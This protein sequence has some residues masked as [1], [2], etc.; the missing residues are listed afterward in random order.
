MNNSKAVCK[1][2]WELGSACG[3]CERCES[4]RPSEVNI[5]PAPTYPKPPAPT[6]PAPPMPTIKPAPTIQDQ[7]AKRAD[8]YV[9][10]AGLPLYTDLF[11]QNVNLKIEMRALAAKLDA[12]EKALK[13]ANADADM[14]AHAWQRE[15]SEYNGLIRNKRH[16]I[17]AMV[18]TTQAF[19]AKLKAAE[20]ALANVQPLPSPPPVTRE[21]ITIAMSEAANGIPFRVVYSDLIEYSDRL[22]SKF[23]A[24]PGRPIPAGQD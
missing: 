11:K 6:R 2:A 7:Y 17:D 22:L 9:R 14:Y 13:N 23:I 20:T 19:V 5:N 10:V 12:S 15:L 24:V 18:L 16:H 21:A 1:G 3:Q 4:T 8:A